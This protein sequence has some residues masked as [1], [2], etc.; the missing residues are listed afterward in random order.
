MLTREMTNVSNASLHYT[1]CITTIPP[2]LR[3]YVSTTGS[4]AISKRARRP[5]RL[6]PHPVPLSRRTRGERDTSTE[7]RTRRTTHDHGQES[8]HSHPQS[9]PDGPNTNTTLAQRR[10]SIGART[11]RYIQH[12]KEAILTAHPQ[13]DEL[14]GYMRGVHLSGFNLC[15]QVFSK[16]PNLK[17]Q[18]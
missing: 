5:K 10:L 7:R 6:D 17:G 15:Q 4:S 9:T 1:Y 8:D 14:L 2:D 11:N 18:T 13:R 16:V 3:L 12:W